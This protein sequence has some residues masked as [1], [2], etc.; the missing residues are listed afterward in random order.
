MKLNQDKIYIVAEIGGNFTTYEQA[1]KLI[2]CAY[3]CGVDAVKLQTY[4]AETIASKKA[5]FDMEN[6]GV[7]SQYDLFKK[8]E[9]GKELHKQVFDYAKCKNLDVFTTPSHV[10]DIPMLEEIGCEIWKVGSDDGVNIPFLKFLAKTGKPIILATGMCTL[11]EVEESVSA[12]LSEGNADLY[13]LH[14]TTDYPTHAEDVNLGAMV[15]LKKNF[16]QLKVGYSDH[17]IGTTACICAAAMGARIIEKHFTYDKNADGPDHMLSASP[18]EMAHIVKCIR[19]FEIMRGSGIK[20]PAKGEKMNRIN[21]RKSIVLAQ[22]VKKG[23]RL[24]KDDI[25]IKRPGGGIYPKYYEQVTGRIAARDLSADDML[26]WED[27]T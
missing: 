22:E 2:D 25:D 3:D 20:M 17:T 19:E 6:V 9:I 16:P 10:S 12:I 21:N 27:L 11:A 15:T 13:L 5:M 4:R 8:F 23:E 14:A 1:V 24:T 26:R 18:E 7:T